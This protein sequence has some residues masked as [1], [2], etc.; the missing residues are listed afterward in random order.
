M[1]AHS[2]HIKLSP[3]L[4]S[5]EL[6]YLDKFMDYGT[7]AASLS[8]GANQWLVAWT[9]DSGPQKFKEDRHEY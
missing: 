6:L 9:V 1:A 5:F 7:I 8:T 3:C 2:R 4:S